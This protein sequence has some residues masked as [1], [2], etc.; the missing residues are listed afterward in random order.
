MLAQLVPCTAE[1]PKRDGAHAYQADA[2]T[3]TLAYQ[4]TAVRGSGAL[5]AAAPPPQHVPHSHDAR[6]SYSASCACA[7]YP[8]GPSATTSAPSSVPLRRPSVM[9]WRSKNQVLRAAAPCWVHVGSTGSTGQ[10]CAPAVSLFKAAWLI[11]RG[12][13]RGVGDSAPSAQAEWTKF[14][15]QQRW[16]QQRQRQRRFAS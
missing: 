6:S 14:I 9:P 15:G 8:P 2:H 5:T 3:R 10:P 4:R 16:Q 13:R 1:K 12:A 7:P 11:G